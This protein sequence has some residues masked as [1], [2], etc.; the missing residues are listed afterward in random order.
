MGEF[1]NG[2]FYQ[3]FGLFKTIVGL[4]VATNESFVSGKQVSQKESIEHIF[5]Q[6]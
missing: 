4:P 3:G 2:V 1:V 5:F 6:T